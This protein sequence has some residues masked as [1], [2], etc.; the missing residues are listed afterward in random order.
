MVQ[1]EDQFISARL[2]LVDQDGA[3]KILGV[4][5]GTLAAWR[6]R[7]EGPPFIQVGTAIKYDVAAL[8]KWC[9]ARTITPNPKTK[10]QNA[11]PR[12]KAN[13]K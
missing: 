5:P 13:R 12:R 3:A 6:S 9:K 1:V 8:E 4:V 2:T 10:K 11:K 7:G